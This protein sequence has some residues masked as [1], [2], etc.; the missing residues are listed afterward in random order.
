MRSPSRP[1]FGLLLCIGLALLFAR[2]GGAH[3]HLCF[4]GGEPP[5]SLHLTDANHLLDHHADTHAQAQ[6]AVHSDLDVPLFDDL[7]TKTG[8]LS[9]DLTTL[10]FAAICLAQILRVAQP[11]FGRRRE[12]VDPSP[13]FLFRPPLRG[14]PL[15]AS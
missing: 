5:R 4:D 6:D 15:P 2:T 7:L 9:V 8:K 13:A 12:R 1:G 10:L 3:L 14:P 11:T